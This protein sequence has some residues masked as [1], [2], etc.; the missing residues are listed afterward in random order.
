MK[1][2]DFDTYSALLKEESGMVLTE[3]KV[4]V[5]ESRLT[6][7]ARKW[8][9]NSLETLTLALQGVPDRVLV[10]DI[11]EA[12]VDSETCFFRDGQPFDL[13]QN[14][15]LPYLK[16]ARKKKKLHLWSAGC[17]SGQEPYSIAI[18]L[19]E[20][21]DALNG[22]K[23]DI[24]A[25]DISNA[26][27]EQ[28]SQGVYS[29]FEVQRGLPIQMLVKYFTQNNDQWQVNES[30]R[31]IVTH[32]NINLL[33]PLDDL[34]MYDIIFCRNTLLNF[35]QDT[36]GQ[37]LAEIAEHLERDGFFLLGK[38]ETLMGITEDLVPIP[39]LRGV[40]V[41]HDSP[42]L[43]NGLCVAQTPETKGGL[44]KFIGLK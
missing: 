19:K 30:I 16:S 21:G 41:R 1:L 4:F 9:Y 43:E 36:K 38:D 14:T 25:S 2:T 40:Y 39:D 7:I 12:M 15:L 8:G 34:G 33:Q 23:F 5:L 44:S 22:W 27:L 20:L 10:R 28:A 29:Q 26:L 3:D 32:K 6:P 18:A 31:D 11:V 35:D 42:H 17:S 24:L 37:I 13:L